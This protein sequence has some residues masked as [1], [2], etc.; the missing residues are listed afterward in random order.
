MKS[1]KIRGTTQMA[2]RICGSSSPAEHRI[3]TRGRIR[4]IFGSDNHARVRKKIN[5]NPR[6]FFNKSIYPWIPDLS[7]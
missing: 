3:K 4:I 6:L 1:V 2:V 7:K 5:I